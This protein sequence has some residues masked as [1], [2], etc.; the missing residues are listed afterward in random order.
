MN[1]NLG[2]SAKDIDGE[3]NVCRIDKSPPITVLEERILGVNNN[4]K[5]YPANEDDE[6]EYDHN[7]DGGD[8]VEMLLLGLDILEEWHAIFCLRYKTLTIRKGSGKSHRL[9]Q[10]QINVENT[11]VDSIVI[12]F[13]GAKK[14][15]RNINQASSSIP[16]PIKLRGI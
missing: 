6:E 7:R 14:R 2:E 1:L 4:I 12:P 3:G 15:I 13:V 5:N 9:Y 8:R 10:R 11:N 16:L